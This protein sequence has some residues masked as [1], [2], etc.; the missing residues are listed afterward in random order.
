MK[1]NI[2]GFQEEFPRLLVVFMSEIDVMDVAVNIFAK[3]K[4][5]S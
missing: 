1:I 3:V 2:R 4:K 5:S